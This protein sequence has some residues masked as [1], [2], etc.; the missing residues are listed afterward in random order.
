MSYALFDPKTTDLLL[1]I[2][3]P[4]SYYNRLPE[5]LR[6]RLDQYDAATLAKAKENFIEVA[7][8]RFYSEV[9]PPTQIRK[10][11]TNILGL[12]VLVPISERSVY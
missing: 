6:E 8:K 4:P 5:D 10:S 11:Y 9:K 7:S 2:P 12:V 1:A 3:P